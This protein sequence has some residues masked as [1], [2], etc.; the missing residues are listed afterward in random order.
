MNVIEEVFLQ[1]I[2]REYFYRIFMQYGWKNYIHMTWM[3]L[4]KY[5]YRIFLLNISPEYFCNM[6]E[7]KIYND[8]LFGICVRIGNYRH[9]CF[10]EGIYNWV[11]NPTAKRVEKN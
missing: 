5:F 8:E 4:K 9:I 6:G 11:I 7:K 3:S 10:K 2:C 1:N